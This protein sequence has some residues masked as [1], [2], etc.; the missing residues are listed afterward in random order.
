MSSIIVTVE[1]GIATITLNR[2]DKLNSFNREMALQLQSI[3]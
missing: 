1:G 3:R 2:P